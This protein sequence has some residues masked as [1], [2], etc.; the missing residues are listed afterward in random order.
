MARQLR[1]LQ[2]RQGCVFDRDLLLEA[3]TIPLSPS[4]LTVV[5]GHSGCGKTTALHVWARSLTKDGTPAVIVRFPWFSDSAPDPR[6]TN[7][8]WYGKCSKFMKDA[9]DN[10]SYAAGF[11]ARRGKLV[12]LIAGVK[13][14]V[15]WWFGPT[16][17]AEDAAQLLVTEQT[18]RVAMALRLLVDAA[19]DVSTERRR[20]DPTAAAPV[21]LFDNVDEPSAA[22]F[23]RWRGAGGWQT[24]SLRT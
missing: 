17:G 2:T 22:S 4:H 10:V 9:L 24:S 19:C 15:E 20:T 11:P 23:W 1:E 16:T 12:T 7:E 18:E 3:A 21:M 6:V 8:Y 14:M 5:L 13:N